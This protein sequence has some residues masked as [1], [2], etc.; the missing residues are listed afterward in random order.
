MKIIS[1]I[2]NSEI[3]KKILKHLDLWDCKARSPPKSKKSFQV[4]EARIDYSHRGIGP[5]GPEAASQFSPSDDHLFYDPDNIRQPLHFVVDMVSEYDIDPQI[6][7][8]I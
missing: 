6:G 5:Y 3:I 4:T 1:V 8:V 7:Y 2:D